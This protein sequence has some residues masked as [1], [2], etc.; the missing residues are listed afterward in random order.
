MK[1]NSSNVYMTDEMI[2][3]YYSDIIEGLLLNGDYVNEKNA[4]S[5]IRTILECGVNS[6]DLQ[7][8]EYVCMKY[9]DIKQLKNFVEYSSTFSSGYPK[10]KTIVEMAIMAYDEKYGSSFDEVVEISKSR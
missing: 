9:M 7:K 5:L 2:K 8:I 10:N 1:K 6:L 4:I 3:E